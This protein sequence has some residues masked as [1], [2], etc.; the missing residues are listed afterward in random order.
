MIKLSIIITFY[1]NSRY[2]ENCIK[3]IKNIS[4]K[5]IEILIMDDGSNKDE[6]EAINTEIQTIKNKNIVIERNNNNMG[7]GYAKNKAVKMAKGEYIIFL[8][9]DDYIDKNY[10]SKILS[11][12]YKTNADIICTDIATD[13]GDNNIYYESIINNSIIRETDKLVDEGLY[14][15]SSRKLLG[16][17][18]SASACNKAIK[19]CLLVKSPFNENKCDDLTAII[20]II[21]NAQKIIYVDKIN[22]YYC[23]TNNSITRQ[24]TGK[25]KKQ[26]LLDSIDS[27]FKTYD[28]LSNENVLESKIEVFYVNNTIPFIHFSI[29]N[30][31]FFSCLYCL[32][33]LKKK[34]NYK[35]YAKYL[36]VKNPYLY[37]LS[38]LNLYSIE[39]LEKIANK[40]FI[41]LALIIFYGR[42]NYKIK[43]VLGVV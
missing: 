16:N 26:S 22:Y 28:I 10:Y 23:Q 4:E 30:N 7:A 42:I 6:F 18:Y 34:V 17:K 33:Y 20:P 24:K 35:N 31:N 2:I 29:F 21:C 9:C 27:L 32:K 14:E 5:E 15:I 1:N 39:L 8:D 25:K 40:S 19:K 41:T 13:L 3:N 37:R 11:A 12:I 43:K 38:Y 36:I